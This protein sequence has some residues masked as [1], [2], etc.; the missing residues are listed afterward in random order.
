MEVIIYIYT[1]KKKIPT[2][3]DLAVL[4]STSGSTGSS[5]FVKLS[6]ENILD[7]ALNI[8]KYLKINSNHTTITTM[9]P[10]YSYGM[11]IINTHFISGSKIILNN[12]SFF[13]KIFWDK[14][15]K[16]KVNSFGGVPYHYEILKKLKFSNFNLP[17]LKYLTQAGGGMNKDLILYFLKCCKKNNIKFIQMYGQ[18][19]AS[20]RI[21]YLP[22]KIARKKI[23][24]IGKAIPGGH[25]AIRKT[26]K[27]IRWVK[28][29]IKERMYS[30]AT[31]QTSKIYQ[32]LIIKIKY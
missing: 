27:Q 12:Q 15:K 7:N 4:L 25:I 2:H 18:T 11:S 31:A 21:S 1:Q 3:E 9:S 17:S 29:Y 20:P 16:Y 5:K 8:C 30:W 26:K 24:S 19:E 32:K 22:F 23:G 28:Y 14:V 6:K 10:S 13:E